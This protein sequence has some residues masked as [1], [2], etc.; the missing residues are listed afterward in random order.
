M[1]TLQDFARI[2]KDFGCIE[3]VNF[4][5]DTKK[6]IR[7]NKQLEA[8]KNLKRIKHFIMEKLFGKGVNVLYFTAK[9]DKIYD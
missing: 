2:R 6:F 1:R 9:K 7:S 4:S 8:F 3:V 5:T